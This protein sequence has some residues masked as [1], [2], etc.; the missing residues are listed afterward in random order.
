MHQAYAFNDIIVESPA[1]ERLDGV[2]LGLPKRGCH[3]TS[4]LRP[5]VRDYA[6]RLRMKSARAAISFARACS[7][8][9]I[10]ST[11]S[12]PFGGMPQAA[13]PNDAGCLSYLLF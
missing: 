8:F 12:P 5:I 6:L 3:P 13:S 10:L 1:Q 7:S 9:V 11:L 4:D 2:L